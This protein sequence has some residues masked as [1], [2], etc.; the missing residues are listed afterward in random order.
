[1]ATARARDVTTYRDER[2]RDGEFCMDDEKKNGPNNLQLMS[3]CLVEGFR[4]VP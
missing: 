3:V 4:L 2:E 1:M